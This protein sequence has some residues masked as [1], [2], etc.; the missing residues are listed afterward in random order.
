MLSVLLSKLCELV[1]FVGDVL[2]GPDDLFELEHDLLLSL[3][4]RRV[5]TMYHLLPS[6][7]ARKR[8]TDLQ[9]ASRR[10]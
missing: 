1:Q 10:R 9:Y 7:R 4:P 2:L 3:F 5:A 6:V 8:T